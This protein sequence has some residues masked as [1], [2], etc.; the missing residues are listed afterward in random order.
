MLI[1]AMCMNCGFVGT[2]PPN[3]IG[4]DNATNITF[5]DVTIGGG[6]PRCG[7]DMKVID[8]TYDFTGGVMT[9]F[10]Q[11][12]TDQL[13]KVE[14]LLRQGRS[15]QLNQAEVAAQVAAISPALG[16]VIHQAQRHPQWT[17][18]ILITVLLT[19]LQVV[20]AWMAL[21]QQSTLTESDHDA[22]QHDIREAIEAVQPAAPAPLP[23][24]HIAPS[25]PARPAAGSPVESG[26]AEVKPKRKKRPGKTVGK[27][28]RT[29]RR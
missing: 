8:G 7:G 21:H 29:K 23:P 3:F 11:L 19:A 4:G 16:T 22:L 9:A 17:L 2:T 13:R 15:G 1:P 24:A 26:Q 14:S 12:D 28:K 25:A 5:K 20:L 18:P 10:R 27:H 6:C